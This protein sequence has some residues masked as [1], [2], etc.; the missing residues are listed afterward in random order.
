MLILDWFLIFVHFN[1]FILITWATSWTVHFKYVCINFG[2]INSFCTCQRHYFGNN[3]HVSPF[4]RIKWWFR[5][6][7]EWVSILNGPSTTCYCS[8]LLKWEFF[9]LKWELPTCSHPHSS[10]SLFW[11]KGG[12]KQAALILMKNSHFNRT[13]LYVF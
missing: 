13:L 1:L 2:W 4:L 8:V 10:T 6:L 7:L 11:R 9:L 5:F 3:T 12:A